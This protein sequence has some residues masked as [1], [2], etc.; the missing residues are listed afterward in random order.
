MGIGI[1]AGLAMT[2]VLGAS[3]T[4]GYSSLHWEMVLGSLLTRTQGPGTWIL[5]LF[6]HLVMSALIGSLYIKGFRAIRRGGWPVGV[7]F[8]LFHW[9]IG[10]GFFLGM[11]PYF[12]P[13]IPGLLPPPGYL[14]TMMGPGGFVTVL[15]AHVVF[16]LVVGL[17]DRPIPAQHELRTSDET[18]VRPSIREAA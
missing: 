13:L 12:H 9:I 3:G 1:A 10:G 11:L 17:L 7:A 14:G 5:G 8:S 6:L 16:G 2:L 15:A 18:E 4:L